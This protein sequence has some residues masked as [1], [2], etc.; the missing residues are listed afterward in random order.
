MKLYFMIGLP[1]EEEE[2]VREIV[3]TGARF[4]SWEERL[5]HGAWARAFEETGID[6]ARFLGTIPVTA[7]LPW[8][9]LDVGL[10][11]G[12]LVREYRKALANR[13]S[14]PCG[15][16]VGDF[17]HHTNLVDAESDRRR[18][19]CYDCGV[20]CDMSGMREERLVFLRA[21]G[22]DE[23]PAARAPRDEEGAPRE[24]VL[25]KNQRKAPSRAQGVAQRMRLS[26]RKVGK[27]AYRGHLD[28]V[29]VLPRVLRRAEIPVWYT[30]GFHP[31]VDMV[32]GPALSLGVASLCEI[33][34]LK[35]DATIPFDLEGVVERLNAVTESG[36]EFLRARLLGA[37]DAGV[38]KVIEEAEYVA[39]VPEVVLA[40]RGLGGLD[41]LRAAITKARAGSMVVRRVIEGIGKDV[42]V[43]RYLIEVRAGDGR[44]ALE[45]GGIGGAL[46]PI[47][48]RLRI[49]GQGTAKASE[50]IEALLGADV[51]HRLVRVGLY[52]GRAGRRVDVLDLDALRVRPAIDAAPP[53]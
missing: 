14:P 2:D 18:L 15:K 44:E 50:V 27:A 7:R 51:P 45:A 39:G 36:L 21:L 33:V 41:A 25:P 32:F 20:A 5:D 17:V 34:D 19:V 23:R 29:R 1:T 26:F 53:S 3:R 52:A 46:V 4:D 9:H 35:I 6:P 28:L 48:M 24:K 49:T 30:E 38:N 43:A 31:R 42:D 12:F 16:A 8:D 37:P 47:T 40:E 13:L 10:E 11:D 22:A